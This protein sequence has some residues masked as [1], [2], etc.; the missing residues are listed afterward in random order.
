MN[1]LNNV[2]STP[3]VST[4]DF[5]VLR[6]LLSNKRPNGTEE[7]TA[8]SVLGGYKDIKYFYNAKGIFMCAVLDVHGTEKEKAAIGIKTIFSSHLDTVEHNHGTNELIVKDGMVTVKGGGVLGADDASG[9]FAMIQMIDANVKGRYMFFAGEE[10]GAIGSNYMVDNYPALFTGINRAIAFDR[11]GTGDVVVEQYVG[12]CASPQLGVAL[13]DALSMG[14]TY[15]YEPCIGVFTD[16]AIMI[17][18]VPECVNI[19]SGYYSEHTQNECLD[20]V[21]LESL[22][23]RCIALDWDA[24]PTVRDNTKVER[25]DKYEKY[26]SKYDVGTKW[27]SLKS[28]L[29]DYGIDDYNDDD[30]NYEDIDAVLDLMALHGLTV[31]D[32]I[33]RIKETGEYDLM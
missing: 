14:D 13:A 27:S 11:K 10:C 21:Y 8:K 9:V 22:I 17:G 29:T 31:T 30:F 1:T 19:S 2:T 4:M 6:Y 16:T 18:L 7:V 5:T 24:L 23:K 20:I 3:K 28:S 26:S 12:V 15:L 32:V 33:G 25:Y